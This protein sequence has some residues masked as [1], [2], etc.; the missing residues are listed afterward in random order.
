M[1]ISDELVACTCP[2]AQRLA[3]TIARMPALTAG[4]RLD[5]ASTTAARAGSAAAV[6]V[7]V[8]VTSPESLPFAGETGPGSGLQIRHRRFDS[9]RSLCF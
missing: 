5:Q 9:D 6:V 1:A 2:V 7:T 3:C 8:V 4:G